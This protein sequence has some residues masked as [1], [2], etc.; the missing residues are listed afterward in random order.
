MNKSKKVLSLTY[1]PNQTPGFRF[2]NAQNIQ[3]PL[4]MPAYILTGLKK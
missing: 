2:D 3:Y 1:F 4:P